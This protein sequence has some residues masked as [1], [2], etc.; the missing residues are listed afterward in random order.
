MINGAWNFLEFAF[1]FYYWVET[2]GK[3]LEEI[4]E[5]LDGAKHS[6]VPDLEKVLNEKLGGGDVDVDV[7][8]LVGMDGSGSVVYVMESI[9][10]KKELS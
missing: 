8:V 3:T 10:E 6:A 5:M 4:D 7:D 9:V 1:V 2:R